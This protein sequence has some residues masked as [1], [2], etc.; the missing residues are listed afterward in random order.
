MKLHIYYFINIIVNLIL[1]DKINCLL[2]LVN[3]N[4]HSIFCKIIYFKI[5]YIHL[6]R[7][8]K[9]FKNHIKN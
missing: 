6:N 3:I 9:S 2:A 8:N 7:L 4:L 5:A 1:N